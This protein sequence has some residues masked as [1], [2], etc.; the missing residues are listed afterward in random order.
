MDRE[1]LTKIIESNKEANWWKSNLFQNVVRPQL[2]NELEIVLPPPDEGDNYNCFAFV[3]GLE[4][5]PEFLGGK[6]PIQSEFVEHL[7]RMK[8]L[9]STD[10]PA[11]RDFIFYKI[12]TGKITHGGIVESV[13]QVISKWM[14]GP[15]VRHKLLDVPSSFGDVHLFFKSVPSFKIKEEYIAYKASGVEIK[16]IG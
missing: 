16:P 5:D 4:N 7:I 12:K 14:W 8:A 3:F 15:V 10:L 1:Q 11:S 9:T 6:N 13:N 2:P